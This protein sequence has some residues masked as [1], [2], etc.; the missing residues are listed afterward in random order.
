MYDRMIFLR[1]G[2][3]LVLAIVVLATARNLRNMLVKDIL[4]SNDYNSGGDSTMDY[5]Y[6]LVYASPSSLTE[7][8]TN[9][10]VSTVESDDSTKTIKTMTKAQHPK[11]T[12]PTNSST[13][14]YTP[15]A[16]G[17]NLWEDSPVIPTWLKDYFTWHAQV[18][19]NLTQDN[20]Q[21]EARY[22]I[23]IA[24]A[25]HR[26]GGM[27]DRLRPLPAYLRL[28]AQTQR[29]LLL[30]WGRPCALEEFLLPPKGGLDWRVPDYVREVV[31]STSQARNWPKIE[32]AA[33]S[34]AQLVTTQ[35]QSWNYGELW[36]KEQAA[37]AGTNETDLYQAF[38]DIWKVLFT[39]TPPVAQRIHDNFVRMN[40]QPGEFAT[41]HLRVLY[42]VKDRPFQKITS[43][44]QNALNCASNLRPGGPF[45]VA[46]D[47]ADAVQV[48]IKYGYYKNVTVVAANHPHIPLHVDRH[49]ITPESNITAADFY[50][51]FVDM[52]LM[53]AT[54]W[55]V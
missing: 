43:I 32:H 33:R 23:P 37:A 47:S 26:S 42:A 7:A 21:F 13:F 24:A 46:S 28:A 16:T 15:L 30:Y 20:W 11:Y 9:A 38:R 14:Q 49:D 53:A 50:D 8:T 29:L 17:K 19:Q 48:A 41:A 10:T 4:G 39:P 18:R 55:Y 3:R 5:L 44:T 52:F 6:W 31:T 54:R 51:G 1:S 45:F 36:Y 22:L 2:Q 35:Y 34:Q 40:L 25:G 27:T 12:S